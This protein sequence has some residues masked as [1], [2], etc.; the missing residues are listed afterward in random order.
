MNEADDGDRNHSCS[1][2]YNKQ[3]QTMMVTAMEAMQLWCGETEPMMLMVM[4]QK[5]G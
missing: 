3:E 2:I 4:N 1:N 5:K